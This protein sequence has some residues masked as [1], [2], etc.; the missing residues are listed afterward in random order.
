[1]NKNIN[2][3]ITLVA[4]II[5]IIVLLI[6]AVVTIREITGDGIIA[7][8]KNAREQWSIE[9]E[10]EAISFSL[11]TYQMADGKQPKL[12]TELYN[13][14]LYNGERWD[15]VFT[16]ERNCGTDWT[17]IEKGT[18]VA[19]Y[20]KTQY[21]WVI[22]YNTGEITY[23]EEKKYDKL[24]YTESVAIRGEELVMNIDATNLSN[25]ASW[26]NVENHGKEADGTGGVTYDKENMALTFDGVDDYLELTKPGDFS[27]GFT[28]EMYMNLDRLR[29]NNGIDRDSYIATGLFCKIPSLSAD[30]TLSMRFG[31]ASDPATIAK[32]YIAS[33][34]S[35]EGKNL[36]T[37]TENVEVPHLNDQ[38]YIG[39]EKYITIVYYRYG[40]NNQKDE[41][42]ASFMEQNK[43][44]VLAYYIDGALYGYTGYGRDSYDEGFKIWGGDNVPMFI[45]V[46]PW[47]GD[48][49]SLYYLK[50]K[51]Y[52]VRLYTRSLDSDEVQANYHQT[53]TYRENLKKLEQ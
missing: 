24:D 18:E 42:I 27:N 25:E 6:L 40:K 28:F 9:S 14:D 38:D 49:S 16:D 44:D 19:D 10:R 22:N 43:C 32:F 8:A 39:K 48:C 4:L 41:E 11:L 26:K 17:Y 2:R 34:W 47:I 23:L 50:G 15:M 37:G 30:A 35:G 7:H 51:V 46:C 29:Y 33:G 52:T 36:R 5:T 12:G 31:Y 1:M 53:L 3:G 13:K 20:G 45:G 21:N